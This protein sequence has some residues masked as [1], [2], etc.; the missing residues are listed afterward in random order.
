MHIGKIW[1]KTKMKRLLNDSFDALSVG[2]NIIAL[3]SIT[4]NK[5]SF[6]ILRFFRTDPY[7]VR[8]CLSL[9]SVRRFL[10]I[11]YT[12]W[13]ILIQYES[14]I[15]IEIGSSC[16]KPIFWIEPLKIQALKFKVT[17]FQ[18][19]ACLPPLEW[20]FRNIPTTKQ[21][22]RVLWVHFCRAL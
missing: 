12:G 16:W 20:N 5:T 14:P 15:L 18:V 9:N 2:N 11:C 17:V 10:N 3:C 6:V 8:C 19:P 13:D 4:S 1:N 7:S 21:C 22:Y